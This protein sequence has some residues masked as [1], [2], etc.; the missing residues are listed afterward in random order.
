MGA[1]TLLPPLFLTRPT[2][3]QTSLVEKVAYQG[4]GKA[5]NWWS[6]IFIVEIKYFVR[7][8]IELQKRNMYLVCLFSNKAI[9]YFLLFICI[10]WYR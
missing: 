10:F 8:I 9:F 1:P 5:A 6:I 2:A 4:P 3:G 7:V